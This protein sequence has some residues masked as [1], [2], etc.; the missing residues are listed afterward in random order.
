MARTEPRRREACSTPGVHTAGW[1]EAGQAKDGRGLGRPS[2]VGSQLDVGAEVAVRG[3]HG[4]ERGEPGH[5][6]MGKE[7]FHCAG[8]C[9]N[10]RE[11]ESWTSRN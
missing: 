3:H 11:A 2:S 7:V 1:R 5:A 9:A 6:V 8:G 4:A 10:V